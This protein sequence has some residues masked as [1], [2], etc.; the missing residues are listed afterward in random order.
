MSRGSIWSITGAT[1]RITGL[2]KWSILF[3]KWTWSEIQLKMSWG[4]IWSITGVTKRSIL[5]Q[6]NMSGGPIENE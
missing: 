3:L 1:K 6:V 2:T 5:S 4:P